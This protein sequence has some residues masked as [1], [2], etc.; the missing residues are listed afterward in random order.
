M[1][2]TPTQARQLL[3]VLRTSFALAWLSPVA[4]GKLFG[5]RSAETDVSLPFLIRLFAARDGALG[6]LTA[7][8]PADRQKQ[9]LTVGIAVDA[10]DLFAA[11]LMAKDRRVPRLTVLASALAAAG[12]VVLGLLA[13][14]E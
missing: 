4:T 1:P 10:A 13:T 9:A 7:L 12:A 5:F 6:A 8:T 14:K 2:I 3:V 11:V